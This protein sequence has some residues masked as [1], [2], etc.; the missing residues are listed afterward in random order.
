MVHNWT[1]AHWYLTTNH[2]SPVRVGYADSAGS[3]TDS[4]KLPLSGGTINGSITVYGNYATSGE[5]Y[6]GYQFK[7]GSGSD[8]PYLNNPYGAD[9]WRA[10]GSAWF[11][12]GPVGST[13]FF[14]TSR[15]SVKTQIESFSRSA[16]DLINT[17]DVV[18]YRYKNDLNNKRIGFIAEDT[19]EELATQSHDQMD[20]NSS[21]GLLIKAVQELSLENKE[22][23]NELTLLK[24]T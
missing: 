8:T 5:I 12:Y 23:R 18:E 1:G 3:A 19:I 7:C 17:V 16:L 11:T 2:G 13:N 6:T 20:L 9:H 14:S 24:T 10:A 22:L 15:R 21:I 4:S